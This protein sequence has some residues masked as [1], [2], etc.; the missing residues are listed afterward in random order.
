MAKRK[1]SKKEISEEARREAENLPSVRLLRELFEKGMADLEVRRRAG[2][3]VEP[4]NG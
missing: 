2:E 4:G 1:R 3:R